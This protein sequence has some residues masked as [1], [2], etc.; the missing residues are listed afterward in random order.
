MI[1]GPGTRV[2]VPTMDQVRAPNL[3]IREWHGKIKLD[4]LGNDVAC[5]RVEHR[6][7]NISIDLL[8]KDKVSSRHVF[9]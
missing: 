8:A 2:A 5:R 4:R 3:K 7:L 1:V 9:S 6:D